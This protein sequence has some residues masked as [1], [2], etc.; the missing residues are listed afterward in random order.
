M[1]KVTQLP[2]S[3]NTLSGSPPF[4]GTRARLLSFGR[5]TIHKL[6]EDPRIRE[7]AVPTLLC[8]KG[9]ALEPS[10]IE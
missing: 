7:T 6:S 2:L 10:M 8:N 9:I 1:D 4:H 3:E 5:D